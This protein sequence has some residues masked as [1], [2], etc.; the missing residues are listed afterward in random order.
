M[1]CPLISDG[2]Q[3]VG[4]CFLTDNFILGSIPLHSHNRLIYIYKDENALTAYWLGFW[5]KKEKKSYVGACEEGTFIS[6]STTK[7]IM[8]NHNVDDMKDAIHPTGH[9]WNLFTLFA[10]VPR[11]V[12]VKYKKRI[13]AQSIYSGEKAHLIEYLPFSPFLPLPRIISFI[14]H[15][16]VGNPWLFAHELHEISDPRNVYVVRRTH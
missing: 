15:K 4:F 9:T 2:K 13:L 16:L 7:Q 8:M 5:T 12:S 6:E 10:C 3:L 11:M 14:N 1:K